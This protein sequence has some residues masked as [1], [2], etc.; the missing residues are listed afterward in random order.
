MVWARLEKNKQTPFS[1]RPP[2]LISSNKLV[3]L[4]VSVAPNSIPSLILP[5]LYPHIVNL[6]TLAQKH[7]RVW[8]KQASAFPMH[9]RKHA[10]KT[11]PH[12]PTPSVKFYTSVGTYVTFSSCHKC[13]ISVTYIWL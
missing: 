13:F 8:Q 5:I 10:S 3:H 9:T 7:E 1:L 2:Q 12:P 11:T 4:L 6:N